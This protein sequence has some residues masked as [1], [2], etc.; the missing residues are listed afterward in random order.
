MYKSASSVVGVF[1]KL[2]FFDFVEVLLIGLY[3]SIYA[4]LGF[5]CV[6]DVQQLMHK[7]M[8]SMESQWN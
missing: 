5:I 6:T 8:D 1:I 3:N 7:S 2:F 4:Q